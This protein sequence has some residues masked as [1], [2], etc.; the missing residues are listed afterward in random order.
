[1]IEVFWAIAPNIDQP[2]SLE[3]MDVCLEPAYSAVVKDRNKT[4]E[5][6]SCPA[7]TGFFRN[8]FLVRSPL[9]IEFDV[10]KEGLISSSKLDHWFLNSFIS[11][12]KTVGEDKYK[13]FQILFSPIIFYTRHNVE[14]QQVPAFMENSSIQSNL[15][16]I[17]GAFNISKWFRPVSF[18]FEVIDTTKPVIVK[19]GDPL[20]Y[21]KFITPG[22]SKVTLTQ[23]DFSDDLSK[24]KNK[25]VSL[26]SLIPRLPL[27]ECYL[28]AAKTICNFWRGRR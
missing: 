7:V 17:P 27:D 26:K 16:V 15:R 11:T 6:L 19:R 23:T 28:M 25:C 9:D 22:G 5:Y 20:Y 21:V 3:L 14:I 1:M 18:A 24:L 4:S 10:T 2:A 12:S 8:T 13:F